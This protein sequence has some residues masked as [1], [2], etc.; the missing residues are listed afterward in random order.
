MFYKIY[1]KKIF[2]E[3]VHKLALHIYTLLFFLIGL[4]VNNSL[5]T[6]L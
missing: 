1:Y 6:G 4:Q 3:L 2:P 5:T